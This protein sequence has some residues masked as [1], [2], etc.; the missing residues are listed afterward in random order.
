MSAP[1]DPATPCELCRLAVGPSPVPLAGAERT[2]LFCC[3]GCKG[4]YRMLHD[5]DEGPPAADDNR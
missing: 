2:F 4:I 5:I 3:E 1:V